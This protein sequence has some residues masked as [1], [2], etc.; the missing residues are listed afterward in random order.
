MVRQSIS[1]MGLNDKWLKAQIEKEEYTSKSE[2]VNDLIRKARHIETIHEH[3]VKA[4]N[5]G[6]VTQSK[7]EILMEFKEKFGKHGSL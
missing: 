6:F 2:I 4:E 7:D 3:L 1:L 5:S